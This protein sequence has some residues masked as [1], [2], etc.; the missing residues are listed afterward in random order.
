MNLFNVQSY[1][2]QLIVGAVILFAVV[3]DQWRRRQSR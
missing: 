3:L 2:Q 1:W